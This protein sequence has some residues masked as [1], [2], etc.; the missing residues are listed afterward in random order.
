MNRIILTSCFDGNNFFINDTTDRTLDQYFNRLDKDGNG[1]LNANDFTS[2]VPN[3]HDVR[4][5]L[6]RDLRS[7]MD[8]DHDG[9]ITKIE[10]YSFFIYDAIRK[11][12]S[13][14]TTSGR[15]VSDMVM[16]R[17]QLNV[18]INLN[19]NKRYQAIA[20]II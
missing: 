2:S 3:V 19:V 20:H 1:Y 15:F 11:T 6:W 8:F 14:F 10:F 16:M 12:Q 18:E 5:A 17:D 4:Q 7:N 13:L 9:K